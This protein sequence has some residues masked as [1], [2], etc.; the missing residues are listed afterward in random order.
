MTLPVLGLQKPR[1]HVRGHGV[2]QDERGGAFQVVVVGVVAGDAVGLAG[3]RA[4]PQHRVAGLAAEQFRVD[5]V[6]AG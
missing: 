1:E 2:V 6:G 3:D 4:P 5:G